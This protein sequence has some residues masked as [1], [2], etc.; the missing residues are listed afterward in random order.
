V[1]LAL[2]VILAS[3]RAAA[4][5][6]T[7]EGIHA[8]IR[9]D[10]DTA[11]RVLRPLAESTTQADPLAQFFL[12]SLY[13]S[14]HGVAPDPI[15]ACALY[16]KAA[17]AAN[18]F[19]H[20]SL[21]LADLLAEPLSHLPRPW[22]E[23]C[24][25][26]AGVWLEPSPASFTLGPDHRV[27]IDQAG[28]T[29]SYRGAEKR[30]TGSFGGPGFVFAPVRYTPVDVSRPLEMRRH[31]LQYFFWTPYQ[32]ADQ[33][34]WLLGWTVQEIVGLDIVPVAGDADLTT[35]AGAQP[36]AFDADGLAG[37]HTNSD[38]EAEWVVVAG[39]NP[40]RAV[41]PYRGPR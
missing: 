5:G 2:L 24:A 6:T 41:I 3:S 15:H 32:L 26:D 17:N 22:N 31:F 10:Y 23:A 20:Q 7:A 28:V 27:T 36:P 21:V 30:A 39:P 35:A 11:V 19:A 25:A 13:Q 1:S 40:R 9:G 38:G 14:G 16:R 8:L 18:P 29:V 34:A 37:V 12:A 33:R 4:Q